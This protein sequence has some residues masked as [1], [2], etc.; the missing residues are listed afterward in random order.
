MAPMLM[1]LLLLIGTAHTGLAAQEA[2]IGPRLISIKA[3]DGVD[4]KGDEYGSGERA[5][6]LLHGGRFDRTSWKEQ[7]EVLAARGFR[8]LAIDFRASVA[9]RKGEETPCLYDASCLAKDVLAAVRHLRLAGVKQ[10]S[11]VGGSLGGGAAAQASIEAEAGEIDRIV[12]LAHMPIAEP[13]RM[14]GRKLFITARDDRGGSGRPRLEGI[15]AQFE[16]APQPKRLVI[17]E[18]GAH[19][20]FIFATDQGP[21]LLEEILRFLQEP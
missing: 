19:A 17:L 16:R 13:E 15:S 12:L 8:V 11:I 4:V 21:R 6:I 20:Q 2:T 3:P 5:V 7:A 10:V 1:S 9:S 14:K 18:G